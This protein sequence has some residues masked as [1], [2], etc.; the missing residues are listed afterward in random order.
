M[1]V[2]CRTC[3]GAGIRWRVPV[4]Q[5]VIVRLFPDLHGFDD[6]AA[7]ETVPCRCQDCKGTGKTTVTR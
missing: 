5:L 7:G 3:R 6:R 2:R 4:D 1:I